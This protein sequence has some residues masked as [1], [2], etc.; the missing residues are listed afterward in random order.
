MFAR[1][2]SARAPR[3]FSSGSS[4]PFGA[5]VKLLNVRQIERAQRACP[6]ALAAHVA[7][8]IAPEDFQFGW[9][10]G[11]VRKMRPPSKSVRSRSKTITFGA[12]SR[13]VFAK[14]SRASATA[15]KN[16]QAIASDMT[17]VLPLPSPF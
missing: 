14:S 2:A 6:L 1:E 16:C 13:K 12:I 7:L 15:L 9:D 4:S 5:F 10:D 8:E 11:S 17:L 3:S